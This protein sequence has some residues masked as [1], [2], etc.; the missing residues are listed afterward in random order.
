MPTIP[1]RS[2]Q[3]VASNKLSAAPALINQGIAGNVRAP[4]IS[5]QIR[6]APQRQTFIP[7]SDQLG[8]VVAH[9]GQQVGSAMMV[10]AEKDAEATAREA[11]TAYEA[12]ASVAWLGTDEVPG[13]AGLKGRA[14]VNAQEGYQN[15]LA[16]S[17]AAIAGSLGDS[18]KAK[19]LVRTQGTFVGYRNQ[20][21]AHAVNSRAVRDNEVRQAELSQHWAKVSNTL[22]TGNANAA[23]A[24]TAGFVAG[25]ASQTPD[26]PPALVQ[27][28]TQDYHKGMVSY[29]ATTEGAPD[30]LALYTD[31]HKGTMDMATRTQAN[32]A[33]ARAVEVAN[34]RQRRFDSD[35][36]S[37]RIKL[38]QAND[39]EWFVQGRKNTTA[40]DL[41]E[42]LKMVELGQ[43]SPTVFL[44]V[45]ARDQNQGWRP[46]MPPA[47]ANQLEL[48]FLVGEKTEEEVMAEV[49]DYDG[50][51]QGHF[52]N[53][54]NNR[55]LSQH[56]TSLASATKRL[57]DSIR[58]AT[59]GILGEQNAYEASQLL[60]GRL[61][62]K[63][64]V[65]SPDQL[66]NEILP[67]F[68][69]GAETAPMVETFDSA[70][71]LS[72][73]LLTPMGVLKAARAYNK[74]GLISDDRLAQIFA[75]YQGQIQAQ[76]ASDNQNL[77]E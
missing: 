58:S 41:E 76:T 9:V 56:K 31:L 51:T 23:L 35:A 32:N 46:A 6:T 5:A 39:R 42:G 16:S 77:G 65:L 1:Q 17:R 75:S 73:K 70:P 36:D 19:F 67:Q 10:M 13:Y 43:L 54:V 45:E 57:Q 12:A 21:A 59:F 50:E 47:D 24:E 14:A 33:Q 44:A 74:Q 63:N 53:L 34:A 2:L 20:G 71:P 26:M 52:D 7:E 11:A 48:Q 40:L 22:A 28:M 4:Q 15:S 37:V 69:R 3:T 60:R 29:L 38:R 68:V 64:N 55:K 66:V 30:K 27:K 72:W 8:K 61:M 18:A 25:I 49:L 62:D